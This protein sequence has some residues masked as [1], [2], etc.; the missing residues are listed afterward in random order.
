MY[1]HSYV[2]LYTSIGKRSMRP[3]YAGQ[4]RDTTS[5]ARVCHRRPLIVF[6]YHGVALLWTFR[7]KGGGVDARIAANETTHIMSYIRPEN[8]WWKWRQ[9]VK[10]SRHKIG[11]TEASGDLQLAGWSLRKR[12]LLKENWASLEYFMNKWCTMHM[13]TSI[14]GLYKPLTGVKYYFDS[15]LF[16]RHSESLSVSESVGLKVFRRMVDSM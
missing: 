8:V 4:I 2:L 14:S 13:A 16:V 9:V 12:R 15:F 3:S 11:R 7:G 5:V 1:V 6:G 10:Q